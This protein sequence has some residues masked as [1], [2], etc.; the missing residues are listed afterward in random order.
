MQSLFKFEQLLLEVLLS[1]A[2]YIS[3]FFIVVYFLQ[4]LNLLVED[5]LLLRQFLDL[6]YQL[7]VL[8]LKSRSLLQ[9]SL[10]LKICPSP[11]I[12]LLI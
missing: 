1:K 10:P 3:S 5:F 12:F 2:L 8:L 6:H 9:S 7:F 11:S 4:K